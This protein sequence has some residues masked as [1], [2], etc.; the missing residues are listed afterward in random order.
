MA[1][2]GARRH[3][4]VFE[5]QTG[6]ADGFGEPGGTWSE[7][8]RAWGR[9]SPVGADE[10]VEGTVYH[11]ATYRAEVPMADT[12]FLDSTH[13]VLWQGRTLNITGLVIVD[14]RGVYQELLLRESTQEGH[15]GA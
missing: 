8:G 15:D 6:A 7:A 2:A 14:P 11:E 3:L 5:E 10:R 1:R 13:R 12:A 9:V 4:L